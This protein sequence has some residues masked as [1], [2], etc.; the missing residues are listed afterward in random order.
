[1]RVRSSPRWSVTSTSSARPER[2]NKSEKRSPETEKTRPVGEGAKVPAINQRM[3]EREPT[4]MR[5][6]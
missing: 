1:V 6:P 3:R 5:S 4:D 2:A